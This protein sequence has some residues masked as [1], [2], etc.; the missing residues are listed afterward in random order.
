MAVESKSHLTRS[1]ETEWAVPR[2]IGIRSGCGAVALVDGEEQ[3]ASP[4]ADFLKLAAV[5]AGEVN[6]GSHLKSLAAHFPSLHIVQI[7]SGV[8]GHFQVSNLFAAWANLAAKNKARRI[9]TYNNLAVRHPGNLI[10]PAHLVKKGV[11]C[12]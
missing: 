2:G 11:G 12:F 9:V 5:H 8:V 3:I 7:C 4:F 10:D 1:G 6:N